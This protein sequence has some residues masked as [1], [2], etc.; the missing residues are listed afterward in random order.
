M[1][2]SPLKS[3]VQHAHSPR[4]GNT[5]KGPKKSSCTHMEKSGPR[6]GKDLPGWCRLGTT[7]PTPSPSPTA[8]SSS[9][10]RAASARKERHSRVPGRWKARER[11]LLGPTLCQGECLWLRVLWQ[12]PAPSTPLSARAAQTCGGP[13]GQLHNSAHPQ[14]TDRNGCHLLS[15][16]C[17]PAVRRAPRFSRVIIISPLN[18]LSE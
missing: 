2:A 9:L 14:H 13:S 15:S 3:P 11:R 5:G 16:Y 18:K 10:G 17:V 4:L 6:E 12:C 7:S 1:A 8:P